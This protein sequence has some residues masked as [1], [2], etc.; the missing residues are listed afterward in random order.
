MSDATKA[1]SGALS[2]V[3]LLQAG[4]SLINA[5]TNAMANGKSEVPKEEL[6][7]HLAALDVQI[8]ELEDRLRG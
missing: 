7:A 4:L 8:A 6:Q 1:V 5:A 3:Q 2:V